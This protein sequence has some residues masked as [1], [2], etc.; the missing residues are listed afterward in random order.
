[1]DWSSSSCTQ[2]LLARRRVTR[3]RRLGSSSSP[4]RTRSPGAGGRTGRWHV[5]PS[6]QLS[7]RPGRRRPS[8]RRT[9]VVFGAVH[10]VIRSGERS[11]RLCT[12]AHGSPCAS[13][14]RTLTFS[15]PKSV[16]VLYALGSPDVVAAV[17]YA[18]TAAVE[19]AIASMSP[20][21]AYTRTGCSTRSCISC[22]DLER[23]AHGVGR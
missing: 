21:S 6:R 14:E 19:Q 4:T 15:A 17:E 1:M 8:W 5:A 22:V 7:R 18:H 9:R 10:P 23:G 11:I 13:P 2:T 20:P 16:S 12:S 3:P